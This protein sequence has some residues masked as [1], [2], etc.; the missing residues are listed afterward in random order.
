MPREWN[1]KPR[2]R[3]KPKSEPTVVMPDAREASELEAGVNGERSNRLVQ[4]GP[5]PISE[6]QNSAT[7]TLGFDDEDGLFQKA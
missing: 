6:Q 2:L 5:T 4:G 1:Y 3:L 7:S